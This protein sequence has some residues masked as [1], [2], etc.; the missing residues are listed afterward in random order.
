MEGEKADKVVVPNVQKQCGVRS[1]EDA[2]P[3]HQRN[4]QIYLS[5]LAERPES[6]ENLNKIKKTEARLP[7]FLFIFRYDIFLFINLL[8]F[9]IFYFSFVSRLGVQL[10]AILPMEIVRV[11]RLPFD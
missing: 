3:A 4:T 7:S 8:I 2:K 9:T 10:Q 5:F 1:P 6:Q 11:R